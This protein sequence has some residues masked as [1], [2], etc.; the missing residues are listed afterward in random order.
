MPAS[1]GVSTHRDNRIYVHVLEWKKDVIELPP[2]SQKILKCYT[3]TGGQPH[4][5]Q[6]K[7]RIQISL[8]EEQRDSIDTILVLDLDGQASA[9]PPIKTDS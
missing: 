7:T 6:T 8:P 4:L 2:L 3:L 5:I 9:I 1:W